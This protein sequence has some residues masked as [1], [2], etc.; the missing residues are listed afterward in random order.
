MSVQARAGYFHSREWAGGGRWWWCVCVCGGG[1][2]GGGGEG[3]GGGAIVNIG[4][5]LMTSSMGIYQKL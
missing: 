2:G 5:I 3:R 1:G 4:I